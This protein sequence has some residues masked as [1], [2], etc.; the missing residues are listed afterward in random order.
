MLAGN[1]AILSGEGALAGIADLAATSLTIF[2]KQP[3]PTTNL[4]DSSPLT[5][6]GS[7]DGSFLLT[8][9]ILDESGGATASCADMTFSQTSEEVIPEP[10]SLVIWLGT[11]FVMRVVAITYRRGNRDMAVGAKTTSQCGKVKVHL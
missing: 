6:T 8:G 7:L 11:L 5:P 3:P 9:E 10:T 4:L 1:V 2:S